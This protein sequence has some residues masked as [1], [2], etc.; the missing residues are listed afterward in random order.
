MHDWQVNIKIYHGVLKTLKR[1]NTIWAEF[2]GLLQT[3]KSMFQNSKYFS[4]KTAKMI[5]F[6]RCRRHANLSEQRAAFLKCFTKTIANQEEPFLKN[7]LSIGLFDCEQ[8]VLV[9]NKSIY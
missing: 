9:R 5:R 2:C 3:I 1:I 4:L 7:T 8:Q 6:G